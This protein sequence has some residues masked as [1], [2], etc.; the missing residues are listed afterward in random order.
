MDDR[1][2]EYKMTLGTQNEWIRLTA[3]ICAALLVP[4][5][6]PLIAQDQPAAADAP[7]P[8]TAD[9]LDSLV[10]PIALYPDPLLAQVLAASTYPLEVVQCAR[11]LKGDGAK[12]KGEELTKAAAKQPW[13]PSVQALV[14]FPDALK[15]LDQNIQ[16]T[17]DLGNAFLD[18]QGDVMDAVQR[19]RMKAKNAG[20]LEST[21]EQKVEVKTVETKT[22]VQIVPSDPQV[23]YVPSY[24]P[25]VVYGAA[26]PV[27]AYP[28]VVY[29]TGA[30]VATAAISFGLGVAMG[31]MW[32]GCCHGGYGW[33][34][35]WGGGNNTI[36][37]NNNFNT[38]YGYNNIQG[39]NRNNVN[40]GNRTNNVGS[41]NRTSQWQHN[42]DHRRS[43]P[44]DNRNTAQ[45]FG[46]SS[47]DAS[48]S[49]QRY[50]RNG[51]ARTSASNRGAQNPGGQNRGAQASARDAGGGR[52]QSGRDNVGNRS[53][54]SSDRSR[55]N[56]AFGGSDSKART[57]AAS[58]RGFSSSRQSSS[59]G[60]GSRSSSGGSRS[61]G[62]GA[63][64][65][66]GGGGRRR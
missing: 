44:Y 60:S 57:Q 45:K 47:R 6:L 33:G 16:W 59:G 64:G 11:W 23:I 21:K 26:P 63:R 27:Y 4:G 20:K 48:G 55:S 54:Q 53:Y 42:S 30:V 50:D 17:T 66:G 2:Q 46:G 1:L 51:Q 29:P 9:Q 15:F 56:S 40:T 5:E 35:G 31:A 14:A 32:S 61:G 18:Q 38:R 13:D 41:G 52:A 7:K 39:G 28:P 37:I 34:C 25:T 62:G 10:A 36:N 24:S 12:L 3:L 19:M 49:T 43:V 22:I 8:K 65:G 58:D